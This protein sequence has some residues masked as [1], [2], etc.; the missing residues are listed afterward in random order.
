[1]DGETL[2]P[3]TL[4][5]KCPECGPVYGEN[6]HLS[7]VGLDLEADTRASCNLCGNVLDMAS[8]SDSKVV[9]PERIVEVNDG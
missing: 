1:M 9:V 8:L 6:V 3:G 7:R 4:V 5:G 2:E